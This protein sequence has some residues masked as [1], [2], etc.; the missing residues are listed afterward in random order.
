M[1]KIIAVANQKG[2]IGKTTTSIAL[3]T[4]LVRK[5]FK[6]LLIDAD[7]QSNASDT[8]RADV[9][10]SLTL[11]DVFEG[12]PIKET[13]QKT[14]IGDIVPGDLQ[15]SNADRLYSNSPKGFYILKE[16]LAPILK[17]YKYIIIDTPPSL[18]VMT[19]NALT[20]ADSLIIPVFAERFS[21]KGIAQLSETINETK[22]YSNPSLT[23]DGILLTC[24]DGRTVLARTL[25]NT[26][27][28]FA[29]ILNTKL[30]DT[31][32][33]RS[34]AMGESQNEQKSIFNYSPSSTTALDYDAFIT[35]YLERKM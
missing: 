28:E 10:N 22:K 19:L 30:F 4:G 25:K 1:A 9:E 31:K 5:G 14:E 16:S 26:L 12:V 29:K 23:I 27:Q 15:L 13:I 18:G 32:I 3:S 21:L 6:T 24:Y 20:A 33:R 17:S 35:E 34:V 8:F 2:G 7:P 11:H